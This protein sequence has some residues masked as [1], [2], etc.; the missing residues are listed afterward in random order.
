MGFA[1]A[2]AVR[3]P[4]CSSEP[5]GLL[6][7][8]CATVPPQKKNL[9]IDSRPRNIPPRSQEE[10]VF[11]FFLNRSPSGRPADRQTNSRR[12]DP[13]VPRTRGS[14][15]PLRGEG[16]FLFFVWPPDVFQSPL[17]F[18]FL[19]PPRCRVGA[20]GRPVGGGVEGQ[21]RRGRALK[22]T[23]GPRLNQFFVPGCIGTYVFRG[24]HR[25]MPPQ[26]SSRDFN[27]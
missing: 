23:L 25:T 12:S 18:S 22:A 16:P 6:C 14:R 27:S 3:E 2:C 19:F 4:E 9:S 7:L 11:F 8:H 20:P 5:C 15:E 13:S 21:A 17:F 10:Y 26:F 1:W 24:A